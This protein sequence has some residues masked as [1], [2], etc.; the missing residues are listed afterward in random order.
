[1]NAFKQC[2]L[3]PRMAD[4]C[5]ERTTMFEFE[6]YFPSLIC[7]SSAHRAGI[8][9]DLGKR[10]KDIIDTVSVFIYFDRKSRSGPTD[11]KPV[12]RKH[13]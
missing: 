2:C 13:V 7:H 9:T 6:I 10:G 1:M 3:K 5:P 11:E 4:E 12:L 8:Q